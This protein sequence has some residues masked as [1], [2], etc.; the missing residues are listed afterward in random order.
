[1][2]SLFTIKQDVKALNS[3]PLWSATVLW[4]T[5]PEIFPRCDGFPGHAGVLSWR[6]ASPLLASDGWWWI[7]TDEA[8]S[9]QGGDLP[10]SSRHQAWQLPT[11]REPY[12]RE[13]GG[14]LK[15]SIPAAGCVDHPTPRSLYLQPE[16]KHRSQALH[17]FPGRD[18]SEPFNSGVAVINTDWLVS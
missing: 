10:L 8:L 7:G 6:V 14:W 16:T 4:V 15:R 5:V 17:C 2:L 12:L 18:F 13:I 3:K 9:P 1:L 11:R